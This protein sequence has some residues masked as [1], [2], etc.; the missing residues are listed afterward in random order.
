M[1]Y[2]NGLGGWFTEKG[3][4]SLEQAEVIATFDSWGQTEHYNRI[5][6]G[7]GTDGYANTVNPALNQN[8]YGVYEGKASSA[9]DLSWRFTI[10]CQT[11]FDDDALRYNELNKINQPKVKVERSCIRDST[12]TS[13]IKHSTKFFYE[14]YP[15]SG[16]S[17]TYF[18][19]FD[20]I[21]PDN[22]NSI[23]FKLDLFAFCAIARGSGW[24]ECLKSGTAST[25]ITLNY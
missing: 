22:T 17:L 2:A 13:R 3:D 14:S 8:Y 12:V 9:N 1:Q 7:L 5:L 4:T 25:N 15:A 23:S 10:Y 18:G 20:I 21:P 11:Y 6:F 24:G 16:E 19:K